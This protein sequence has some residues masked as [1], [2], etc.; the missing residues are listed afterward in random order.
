M[1]AQLLL[2]IAFVASAH[3]EDVVGRHCFTYGEN[4]KHAAPTGFTPYVMS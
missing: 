4:K 1:K 2:M 3:A